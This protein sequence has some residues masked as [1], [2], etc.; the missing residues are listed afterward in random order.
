MTGSLVN[1]SAL[2]LALPLLSPSSPRTRSVAALGLLGGLTTLLK[3]TVLPL[4][5]AAGAVAVSRDERAGGSAFGR[6][7]FSWRSSPWRSPRSW[8][9]TCSSE[10]PPSAFDTRPVVCFPWANARGA[11]GSVDPSP[12][13]MKVLREARGSTLRAATLS[14]GTWKDDPAGL[15]VLLGRKL[16]SAFN[17]AEIP[18]NASF[19]FFRKR[20]WWLGVLPVFACLLGTGVAG[21]VLCRPAP[22]L[23]PRRGCPRRGGRARPAGGMSS[24]LHDDAVSKTLPWRLSG[25]C[26]GLLLAR[27]AEA[28]RERRVAEAIVPCFGAGLLTLQTLL[29]SPVPCS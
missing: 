13:L 6:P 9:G 27:S 21:L 29:P 12:L 5:L 3:Q 26:T 22:S 1:L 19:T 28:F 16:A 23:S 8:R 4:A 18:D 11:D 14:L 25:S 7:P 17:G 15:L 20:L 24:R 2:L 10:L